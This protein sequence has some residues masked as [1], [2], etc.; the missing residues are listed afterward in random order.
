M[1]QEASFNVRGQGHK[2]VE[3]QSGKEPTQV[4]RVLG[5]AIVEIADQ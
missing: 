4:V 5:C 1:I 2:L 3:L